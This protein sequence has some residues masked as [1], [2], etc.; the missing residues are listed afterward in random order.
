[1][2]MTVWAGMGDGGSRSLVCPHKKR[3]DGDVIIGDDRQE[4]NACPR[5]RE[6]GLV[7]SIP[8]VV[9]VVRLGMC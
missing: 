7:V 5:V 4:T 3:L 8:V 6:L 2:A 1:M 9:V